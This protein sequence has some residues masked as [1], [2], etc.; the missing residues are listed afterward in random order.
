[1]KEMLRP[2]SLFLTKELCGLII[3]STPLCVD[4]PL[5]I[6]DASG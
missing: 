5:K 3:V 4:H 1:M 2:N 6:P